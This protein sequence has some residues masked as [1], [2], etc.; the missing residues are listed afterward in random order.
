MKTRNPKTKVQPRKDSGCSS[1]S[2]IQSSK[3]KVQS[4][5]SEPET[6]ITLKSEHRIEPTPHSL[7]AAAPAEAELRSQKRLEPEATWPFIFGGTADS[8]SEQDLTLNPEP[9]A[10]PSPRPSASAFTLVEMLVVIAVIVLLAAMLFPIMSAVGMAKL[11]A[12]TRT[13]LSQLQTAIL[14]YHTSLGYYPPDN[15]GIWATNQLYYEL[16]GTRMTNENG[17]D[18]FYTLDGRSRVAASVLPN[19]F[20]SGSKI[21]G[22][23]NCTRGSGSDEASAR[24]KNCLPNGL[25]PDQ[26]DTFTNAS[27]GSIV[28]LLGTAYD[29]PI[30]FGKVSPWR[31]NSSSPTNNPGSFDLWVDILIGGK[32]NRFCNWNSD[33]LQK[34]S[35]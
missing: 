5:K 21:T 1:K 32:T 25:R 26:Y 15:P 30:M 16:V 28:T 35:D 29:G 24:A 31:Y 20:G 27:A 4:S 34:V 23:M 6:Q 18:V 12:R 17:S 14:Y 2:K 3:F 22:F 9:S 13:Q 19:A 8:N 7:S 10:L 33:M 11:K